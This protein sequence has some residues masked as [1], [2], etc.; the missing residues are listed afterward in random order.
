MLFLPSTHL[1]FINTGIPPPKPILLLILVINHSTSWPKLK[2]NKRDKPIFSLRELWGVRSVCLADSP[3][4]KHWGKQAQS[5][6]GTG[7]ASSDC[8]SQQMTEQGLP[9]GPLP[10]QRREGK[11]HP[12]GYV[13][14]LLTR[15]RPGGLEDRS[16]VPSSWLQQSGLTA[17]QEETHTAAERL[18][19]CGCS[20]F[21]WILVLI[22]NYLYHGKHSSPP[23]SR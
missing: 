3:T 20:K 21:W 5:E 13:L 14:R 2:G 4:R 23:T 22:L 1:L 8:W 6:E 10:R 15:E 9:R 19:A 17:Y 7:T 12:A 16:S 11:L 18:S